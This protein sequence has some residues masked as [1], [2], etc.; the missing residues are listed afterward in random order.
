MAF[1]LFVNIFGRSQCKGQV[2]GT[3]SSINRDH[4]IIIFVR[5]FRN[6]I[7]VMTRDARIHNLL[8]ELQLGRLRNRSSS[9]TFTSRGD[10]LDSNRISDTS[11]RS[12]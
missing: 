8:R 1:T 3:A 5:P 9:L 7:V 12:F 10:F 4:T 6:A 2:T 11:F